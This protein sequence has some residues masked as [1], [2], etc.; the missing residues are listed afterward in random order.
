MPDQ[1]LAIVHPRP[2]R[3]RALIPFAERARLSVFARPH[4]PTSME[5]IAGL[6]LGAQDSTALEISG[7]PFRP[8]LFAHAP[9]ESRLFVPQGAH[10]FVVTAGFREDVY[11]QPDLVSRADGAAFAVRARA[12][13]GTIRVLVDEVLDPRREQAPRRISVTFEPGSLDELQLAIATGPT[14]FYD[15]TYWEAPAFLSTAGR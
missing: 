3:I 4:S 10:A 8:R 11:R 9:F 6:K 7:S 14:N 1:A 12:R 13:D 15:W 2:D 5:L